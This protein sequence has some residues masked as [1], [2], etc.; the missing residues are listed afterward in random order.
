MGTAT[1][2]LLNDALH[3]SK[4]DRAQLAA[5]LIENL[6]CSTSANIEAAW[7]EEIAR[8]IRDVDDGSVKTV[9]WQEARRQILADE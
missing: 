2:K 9:S 5:S 4:R 7:A 6:D 8:R 3:L 1:K